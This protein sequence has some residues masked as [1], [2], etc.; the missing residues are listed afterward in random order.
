VSSSST[1]QGQAGIEDGERRR[2]Q[3][4]GSI[5]FSERDAR[6]LGLIGEQYAVSVEQLARLIGRR[7]RTGRWLRD[8]WR[9]AGWIESRQL[10]HG[11]ASFIW[12]TSAGSRVAGSAYRSWRPNPGLIA[13]IEAVTDVRL[14]LERDL[15][16]GG[17]Q[18]ERALAQRRRAGGELDRHLPD[19]ILH[20]PGG[21]VAI[22][23]EQTLKS[24]SRL[25]AIVE[26]L[27]VSYDE[28]WYFAA[29]PV[30]SVLRELAAQTALQNVHVHRYPALAAELCP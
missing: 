5:R 19:A 16:L 21:A 6:L 27:A 25:E 28:V 17:W 11:G 10:L 12:L 8:R 30:A 29:D 24:R 22:E 4:K 13:H 3:D 2:R 26:E 1:L 7:Q 14:L 23:V 9:R 18:C 15:G 20:R